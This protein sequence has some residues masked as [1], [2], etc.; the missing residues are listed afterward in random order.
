ML[1]RI[2]WRDAIARLHRDTG[3]QNL[4]QHGALGCVGVTQAAQHIELF[5]DVPLQL[6]EHR[7]GGGALI[8]DHVGMTGRNRNADRAAAHRNKHAEIIIGI[9][10]AL[11]LGRIDIGADN[12]FEH[13]AGG[14]CQP[15]FLGKLVEIFLLD[16][17]PVFRI[18]LASTV[19]LDRVIGRIAGDRGQ[20]VVADTEIGGNLRIVGFG[21][22]LVRIAF[23]VAGILDRAFEI[24]ARELRDGR[25]SVGQ[26][27]GIFELAGDVVMLAHL[28]VQDAAHQLVV[29]ARHLAVGTDIID[30]AVFGGELGS[31]AAGQMFGQR[32]GNEAGDIDTLAGDEGGDVHTGFKRIGRHGGN[33]TDRTG[34]GVL[35]EQR[36]LRPAQYLHPLQVEERRHELAVAA[37]I[38]AV[39]IK[40]DI[41]FESEVLG[42]RADAADI[43][44]VGAGGGLNREVRDIFRQI[45]ERADIH[46]F[47]ILAADDGH[48]NRHILHVFH[49]LLGGDQHRFDFLRLC[50]AKRRNRQQCRC[51]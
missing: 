31:Q 40:A 34:G 50:R 38:D 16:R 51:R 46:V 2:G 19:M 35:A 20:R 3:E 7:I 45:L 37:G 14:R 43:D 10:M 17:Q 49:A 24:A 8:E 23:P 4:I 22:V 12:V 1:V 39:D 21:A 28:V 26:R 18:D 6:A 13:A 47:Q 36:A 44:L 15:H 29:A 11:E 25:G 9:E 5:G 33:D 30:I 32:T 48:G 27:I 42:A 41:L